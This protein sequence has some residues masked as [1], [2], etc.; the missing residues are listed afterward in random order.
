MHRPQNPLQF[1]TFDSEQSLKLTTNYLT[2]ALHLFHYP[3]LTPRNKASA[4]FFLIPSPKLKTQTQLGGANNE[5]SYVGTRSRFQY[6][7]RWVTTPTT[8]PAPRFSIGK[9]CPLWILVLS[10]VHKTL[11]YPFC[12]LSSKPVSGFPGKDERYDSLPT[13]AAYRWKYRSTGAVSVWLPPL[14]LTGCIL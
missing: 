12:I 10:L 1:S 14:A 4:P 13:D 3:W 11:K 6:A 8:K 9:S 2:S 7:I 5:Y